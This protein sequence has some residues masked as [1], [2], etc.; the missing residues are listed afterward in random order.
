MNSNQEIQKTIQVV[1][2]GR[3]F[4][5]LFIDY[6]ILTL[7][8]NV[9]LFLIIAPIFNPFQN[10][11]VPPTEIDQSTIILF[12]LVMN[13]I[14]LLIVG[15]Y[16]VS[17]WATKGQT[18]GKMALGIKVVTTNGLPVSFGRAILRFIGYIVGSIIIWLGFIWAGFDGK[19][20]GWHDKMANTYVVHK[21]TQFSSTDAITIVPSDTTTSAIVIVLLLM[22]GPMILVFIMFAILLLFA[23]GSGVAPLI[24]TLF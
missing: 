9:I 16:F 20:Q 3:R 4:A 14:A 5:A 23:S 12:N 8:V 11:S 24:Y 10:I 18:L 2:I 1:G 21:D 17:F 15:I 13:F 7:V 6:L 19:R 22:V